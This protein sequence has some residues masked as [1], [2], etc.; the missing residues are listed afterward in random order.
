[1]STLGSIQTAYSG[2]AAAQLALNVSG[3]N[4]ANELT[5]GY[6][7]EEVQ[8][9][10]VGAPSEEGLTP[11]AL[12]AGQG[13]QVTAITQAGS[14]ILDAQ[15]RLA[16]GQQASTS[17][18]ST[19]LDQIQTTLGEPSA[20]A[21]SGQLQ[22]FWADWQA[23]SNQ[24]TSAAPVNALL[25][26]ATTIVDQLQSTYQNLSTQWD[27]TA[28]DLTNGVDELNSDATQVAALNQ[29]IREATQSGTDADALIV[30]QNNLLDQMATLAGATVTHNAD[31]TVNVAIGG[32]DIVQST[33]AR[34]VQVA[35]A[36]SLDGVEPQVGAAGAP[37]L[38]WADT[39]DVALSVSDGSIGGDLTVLAP[40]ATGGT[41]ATT[42]DALNTLATSLATQ[43]NAISSTSQT[44]GTPPQTGGDFFTVGPS[45][46]PAALTIQVAATGL[47]DVGVTTPGGAIGSAADQISQIGTAQ[48]SPDSGWAASIV[49]LG[50]AAQ[51]ATQQASLAATSQ[52][53]AQTAQQS[54]E[55]VDPN[56]ESV[57]LIAYQN[58][59]E[60]N[61]RVL[62]ALDS[63][64]DTLINHTG[65]VG[66]S[67]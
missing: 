42:A 67:S 51:T 43:V 32:T 20:D 2:L 61:A 16:D 27:A 1:M 7:R 5:P 64:L 33:T 57:N 50:T 60:A 6:I 59:Y 9:S 45:T 29:S 53:A 30:Q 63:M 35:G 10:P 38:V 28:E 22:T 11:T 66:L 55:S 4:T 14:A 17:T 58:A 49:A 15:T 19:A 41:I 21:L 62:T 8:T 13:V 31:G 46:Q 39:P 18:V 44:G 37:R 48:D 23:V 40:A 56:Q 54:Q 47:S 36:T 25:G 12:A 52:S 65:L 3:E 24:P 34:Q 26:Q